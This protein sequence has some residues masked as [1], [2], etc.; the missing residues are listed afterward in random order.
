[1]ENANFLILLERC[2]ANDRLSQEQLY[3]QYYNYGMTVANRYASNRDDAAEIMNDAFVRAMQNLEK[4]NREFPFK[5]W[6]GKIL[7]NCAI[8]HY[9]RFTVRRLDTQPITYAAVVFLASQVWLIAKIMDL[10]Y[11]VSSLKQ[12][13]VA[14]TQPE[15]SVAPEK[16]LETVVQYDTVFKSVV[17]ETPI[18][19]TQL[20][21]DNAN[22]ETAVLDMSEW[23]LLQKRTIIQPAPLMT[24]GW[25]LGVNSLF[26]L[27]E[28]GSKK[29]KVNPG[30]NVR[31]TYD[32]RSNWRLTADVDFWKESHPSRDTISHR[33]PFMP[34]SPDYRL[35]HVDLK[36]KNI[37]VRNRKPGKPNFPIAIRNDERD[38]N[39]A[40]SLS[41]RI[42]AMGKIYRRLGWSANIGKELPFSGKTNQL[43]S[44]QIGFSYAL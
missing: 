4:F 19:K 18:Y 2:Q 33:P 23:L 10:K 38:N 34:P 16:R 28:C 26:V 11:E 43:L 42:G 31:L 13:N 17:I 15:K 14:L 25:T 21:K 7:V 3:R 40:I 6:F 22:R 37:A 41:L 12:E 1:M 29:S 9:R 20:L 30:A 27:S 24:N 44:G 32:L 5:A 35:S 36:S 39:K 8:N